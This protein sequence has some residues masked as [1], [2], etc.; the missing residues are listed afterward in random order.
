MLTRLIREVY[1]CF[2]SALSDR[3]NEIGLT[4]DEYNTL[5]VISTAPSGLRMSDIG[6]GILRDASAAT[7][8]TD[9]L[10]QQGLCRRNMDPSDRRARRVVMTDQGRDAL[11][12]GQS[13]VKG[14]ENDLIAILETDELDSVIDLLERLRASVVS[15]ENN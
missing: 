11:R 9:S 5:A 4:V 2:N 1:L 13:V 14:L 8:I 7:R 15:L 12:G 3:M 10:E 6:A